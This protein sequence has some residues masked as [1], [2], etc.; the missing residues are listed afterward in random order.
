MKE[1]RVPSDRMELAQSIF[2]N[3]NGQTNF[4]NYTVDKQ[5]FD[6]SSTRN[7]E[8][9]KCVEPF[10]CDDVEFTRIEIK[11]QSFMLHQIR[12]M[13]G[14]SL[15]VIRGIVPQSMLKESLTKKKFSVPTAPG[16]GLVL[17]RLH[18]DKYNRLFGDLYG[19]LS[20]D[21]YETEI[22]EFRKKYINPTIIR[23]EIEEE[24]MVSWM[25]FLVNHNYEHVDENTLNDQFDDSWGED[26]ELWKKVEDRFK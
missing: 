3:F 12:K 26:P 4:H 7:I 6:R 16:L 8:Y 19:N 17:E 10:V 24:S 1:Y 23:T 20:F 11:G 2:N 25:D 5:Y 14:F 15:A 22:E 9:I 18:F 13:M 21:N